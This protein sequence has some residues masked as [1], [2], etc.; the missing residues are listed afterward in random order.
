MVS[1]RI[2]L[3]IILCGLIADRAGK[4][5]ITALT[6]YR[7]RCLSYRLYHKKMLPFLCFKESIS[8]YQIRVCKEGF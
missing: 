2:S 5:S 1:T 6:G 3:F 7:V 4:C 8:L